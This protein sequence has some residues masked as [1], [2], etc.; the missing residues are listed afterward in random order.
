MLRKPLAV[1][2][3]RR[4]SGVEEEDEGT[5]G[6]CSEPFEEMTISWQGSAFEAIERKL[7]RQERVEA[8]LFAFKEATLYERGN[9]RSR[10]TKLSSILTT[11]ASCPKL[12]AAAVAMV[13]Y[14]PFCRSI[15]EYPTHH[16]LSRACKKT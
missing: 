4:E 9:T 3:G 5:T 16:A 2:V 8:L 11:V 14:R 6:A 1:K 15:Q 7:S 12:E 13:Q 10:L